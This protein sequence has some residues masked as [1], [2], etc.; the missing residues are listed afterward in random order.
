METQTIA[1]QSTLTGEYLEQILEASANLQATV[2]KLSAQMAAAAAEE[3]K[4]SFNGNL[5]IVNMQT[6]ASL[7]AMQLAHDVF[8]RLWDD[9]LL[10]DSGLHRRERAPYGP[11]PDKVVKPPR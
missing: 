7:R 2:A 1:I 8:I 4:K 6:E 9:A 3:S 10:R 5:R 11:K